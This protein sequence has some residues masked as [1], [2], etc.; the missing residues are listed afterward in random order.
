[1][2]LYIGSIFGM[3]LICFLTKPE[4]GEIDWK[5]N[6]NHWAAVCNPKFTVKDYILFKVAYVEYERY[7]SW[8]TGYNW[9]IGILGKWYQLIHGKII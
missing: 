8:F 9:H 3:S 4:D 1:M 2:F 5:T 7:S 6:T